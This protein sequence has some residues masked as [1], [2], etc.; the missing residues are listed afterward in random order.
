[1]KYKNLN[2]KKLKK[3]QKLKKAHKALT[4]LIKYSKN[5]SLQIVIFSVY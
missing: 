5:I 2:L 1:M 3:A 4:F